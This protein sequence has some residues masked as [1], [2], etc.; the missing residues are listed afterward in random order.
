MIHEINLSQEVK[1]AQKLVTAAAMKLGGVVAL[2]GVGRP[3]TSAL[4]TAI[5]ALQKAAI[6]IAQDAHSLDELGAGLGRGLDDAARVDLLDQAGDAVTDFVQAL[7]AHE[8]GEVEK[9]LEK[10]PDVA[11]AVLLVAEQGK[12]A[13]Q[14]TQ[15]LRIKGPGRTRAEADVVRAGEGVAAVVPGDLAVVLEADPGLHAVGAVD[16]V[17]GTD[18]PAIP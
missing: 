5:E 6:K 11:Q 1:E 12:R 17:P 16:A 7:Q 13:L 8:R 9:M 18:V 15:P 10:H 2:A 14:Q 3:K 4:A